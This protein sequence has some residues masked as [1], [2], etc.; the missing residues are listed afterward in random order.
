VK[1]PDL[2]FVIPAF[3]A[4]DFLSDA[5]LS[6][7][8]QNH[9]NIEIVIVDDGSKDSTR[10][11]IEHFSKSDQRVV[12]VL[13]PK[14]YGRGH[15]RN[16]G[17]ETAT[18]PIIAVLDADD[19]AEEARAKHTLDL[20][21]DG[22]LFGSAAIVDS[23]GRPLG[24]FRAD[25]FDLK[26]AIEKQVNFIVHSTMAYPKKLTE[27]FKYD[28]GEY[29]AL[30]LDDW[31]FQLDMALAGV[32]FTHTEKILS[33]W[34]ENDDQITTIRDTGKVAKLKDQYLKKFAIGGAK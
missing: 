18:A 26:T 28:E 12:G 6:C 9:K 13:L 5:V 22:V 16:L 25:P 1:T 2:S 33:A 8:N 29:A 10:R 17:N 32:Q 4:Q 14:N 30:G 23:V 34:R 15:A 20:I 3:N 11:L 24:R 27:R 31:K 7:L 19:I 21:E